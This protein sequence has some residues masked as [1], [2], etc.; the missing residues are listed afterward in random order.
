MSAD[1]GTG[2]ATDAEIAVDRRLAVTMLF[3]FSGSRSTS[4]SQIFQCAAEAGHFVPLEVIQG[5]NDVGIHDRTPDL[6]FVNVFAVRNGNG[7][8]IGSFQAVPDDDMASD[9]IRCKS[10][11]IRGF[12]VLERVFA[13]TDIQGVAVG[14]KRLAP[15]S[16]N[17]IDHRPSKIRTQKREIAGLAEMDLDRGKTPLE[18]NLIHPRFPHQQFEFALQISPLRLYTHIGKINFRLFHDFSSSDKKSEVLLAVT[19]YRGCLKTRKTP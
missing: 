11:S 14:Q 17:L 13:G 7:D 12:D 8:V 6:R 4:H 5:N 2:M 1:P 18:I 16:Q 10:I 19:E 9:G 3:H 15:K